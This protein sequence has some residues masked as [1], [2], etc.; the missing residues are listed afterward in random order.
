MIAAIVGAIIFIVLMLIIIWLFS[1]A[2]RAW[3]ETPKYI[4]LERNEMFE[5]AEHDHAITTPIA[6]IKA[7][8]ATRH[9]FD[10]L[11]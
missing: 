10:G 7:T 6:I 5:S 9:R 2:F 3:T 4:L 8:S 1:P 11:F